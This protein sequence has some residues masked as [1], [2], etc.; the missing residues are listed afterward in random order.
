MIVRIRHTK[1]MFLGIAEGKRLFLFGGG[2]GHAAGEL[3][4][5]CQKG[6]TVSKDLAEGEAEVA[7]AVPSAVGMLL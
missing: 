1:E 7:E 6:A 4:G 3:R 2:R 5:C